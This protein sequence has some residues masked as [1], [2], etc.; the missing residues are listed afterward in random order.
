MSRSREHCKIACQIEVYGIA[1]Y[2]FRPRAG[3]NTHPRHFLGRN[4]AVVFYSRGTAGQST[5]ALAIIQ[6][7]LSAAARHS[8]QA[9]SA[10]TACL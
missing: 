6:G 2:I 4:A 8:A 5:S 7:S 3:I 1:A 10:I 9:G